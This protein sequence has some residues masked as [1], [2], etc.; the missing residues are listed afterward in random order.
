MQGTFKT[1][2][3]KT[4]INVTSLKTH[5]FNSFTLQ[6]N[7]TT[8]VQYC[9]TQRGHFPFNEHTH[10]SWQHADRRLHIS[11]QSAISLSLTTLRLSQLTRRQL[12]N[13]HR[14]GSVQSHTHTHT[15][16]RPGNSRKVLQ[17]NSPGRTWDQIDVSVIRLSKNVGSSLCIL[18]LVR[19]F[20]LHNKQP[21]LSCWLLFVICGLLR[22]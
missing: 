9:Y 12:W 21:L 10:T 8:S 11:F 19:G 13:Y 7:L 15:L 5:Q 18:L 2:D 3:L 20:E 16:T 4:K 14:L 6:Q 1:A 17:K 22:K